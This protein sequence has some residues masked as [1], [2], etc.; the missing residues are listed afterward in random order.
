MLFRSHFSGLDYYEPRLPC[1]ATQIG[2][3]RSAIGAT[4]LGIGMHPLSQALQEFP[5]MKAN[6]EQAHQLVLGQA[7]PRSPQDATVQMLCRI[8]Y[9]PTPA[10]ATPRRALDKFIVTA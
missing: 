7:A 9:T 10:P 8:G 6:Y 3:F 1:D 4:A 2:R 5:E